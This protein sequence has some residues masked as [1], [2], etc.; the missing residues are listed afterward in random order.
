MKAL[1]VKFYDKKLGKKV[2]AFEA[3]FDLCYDPDNDDVECAFYGY[4]VEYCSCNTVR[5]H[6]E[7]SNSV[8]FLEIKE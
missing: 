1:P 2:Q 3:D 5:R 6:C 4:S 7:V 8:I